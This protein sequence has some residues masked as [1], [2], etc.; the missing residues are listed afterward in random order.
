MSRTVF[1]PITGSLELPMMGGKTSETCRVI[2][3]ENKFETLVHL[4]G[5]TIETHN[6]ARL[7]CIHR[8]VMNKYR[9]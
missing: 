4:A 2:P 1:L 9:L 6:Y 5:F 3:K 8:T 7:L